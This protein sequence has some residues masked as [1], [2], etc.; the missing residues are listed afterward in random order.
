MITFEDFTDRELDR[1]RHYQ[2]VSYAVLAEVREQ[3]VPG[4][5]ERDATRWA[6][7][8]YRREGVERYFHLPVALFGDRT[9][10][11]D[12]P[13]TTQSFFPVDRVLA[14]GDAVVLDASPMFE[15]YLVDT[16]ISFSVGPSPAHASAMADDLS[17]RRTVLEAVRSGATFR[18]IA[19]AVDA[20]MV[21]RGDRNCHQLHP[22][23]VLGHRVVRMDDGPPER[24]ASDF[25]PALIGWFIEGIMAGSPPPVW[26]AKLAS[27][28]PPAPGLWAVEPHLARGDMGVKWEELL[29]VTDTDAFWLDDAVPHLTGK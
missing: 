29:V 24:M 17:Y 13:W 9:T 11:P 10:L 8:A 7:K 22:E 18:E 12:A 15:G 3:C 26:N 6:M 28:H 2:Q 5:T 4:V 25:D 23:A 1:F 16:A 21:G 27:D 20:D 19:L 14:E